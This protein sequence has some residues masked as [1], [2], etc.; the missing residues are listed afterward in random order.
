MIQLT[1]TA[2]QITA[3]LSGMLFDVPQGAARPLLIYVGELPEKRKNGN[4]DDDVAFCLIEPA[5]FR[6]GRVAMGQEVQAT[7]VLYESHSAADGLQ[8]VENTLQRLQPLAGAIF[9]PCSL[10]GDVQGDF[11]QIKH[12]YYRFTL[13]LTLTTA[14]GGI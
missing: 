12:P 11:Q 9:T 14:G 8:M 2:A 13:T 4:E 3:A 7:F 5:G 10:Q 1:K 6:L